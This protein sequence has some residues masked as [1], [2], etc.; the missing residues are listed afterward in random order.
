M[1][2]TFAVTAL[3][4]I[5][6]PGPDQ[7]LITRNALAFGR[8][9]GLLTMFGGLIGLTV[10]ATAAAI[11]LSALLLASA[12]AFTVLKVVGVVY[13]LWLGIQALRSSRRTAAAPEPAALAARS[14]MQHVRNGFLSN[15][16]NP[17]VA[18][19]FVTFLPQFLPAHGDTLNQAMLLSAIFAG[20]YLLW[21][22]FYNV[23]VDRIGALLRTPR[24]RARVE[25]AT[26]LLLVGFAIR[27]AVQQ[28]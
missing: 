17:K 25:Q 14:P 22:S 19:F 24:I 7:A 28:P 12:T 27:L 20:L 5:M 26:G 9:A 1:L 10:H 21:F 8:T 13:L 15:T 11:G 16:L 2:T 4:M 3:V 6:I 18:L 23:A